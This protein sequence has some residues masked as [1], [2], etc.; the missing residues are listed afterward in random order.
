MT[1]RIAT[2]FLF[3]AAGC[4]PQNASL[5][6]GDYTAYLAELSSGSLITG[7]VDFS[8]GDG[9]EGRLDCPCTVTYVESDDD[10]ILDG[11]V[12][13]NDSVYYTGYCWACAEFLDADGDGEPDGSEDDYS[14]WE[15][16]FSEASLNFDFDRDGNGRLSNAELGQWV[17]NP[18]LSGAD[19][20]AYA[21]P[22]YGFE[23]WPHVDTFQSYN[24]PA[25]ETW[26]GEGI[27]TSEGD[28]QVTFHTYLPGGSDFRFGFTIDPNFQ[29]MD[30]IAD[31]DGIIEEEIDGD[32]LAA[33]SDSANYVDGYGPEGNGP[34]FLLNAGS[35]QFDP[36]EDDAWG[37][38][39]AYWYL[40][41]NWQA[42]FAFG[43][44]ADEDAF[45]RRSQYGKPLYYLLGEE[46]LGAP[47]PLYPTYY[48]GVEEGSSVEDD[49]DW[50][51]MVE[52]VTLIA[53]DMVAEY[54][55]LG[56]DNIRPIIQTNAWRDVDGDDVGLDGWLGMHYNWVQF[57]EGSVI[58]VGET[59]TGSYQL[60]LESSESAS[61]FFLRGT[62]EV[63]NIK[64]D[65]WVTNDVL[66]EKFELS[67]NERCGW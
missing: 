48:T 7:S 51:A 38:G 29:P 13:E 30:C 59:V 25:I 33:W 56:L 46:D 65:F 43:K 21:A 54:E 39:T 14:S 19:A 55:G 12:C 8:Q 23:T 58:E 3:L 20:T 40:P 28:F 16:C 17:H 53:D 15:E 57:D 60:I 1:G 5:T 37:V 22:K 67:G 66:A 31:G 26:R 64:E 61:M 4:T 32:W 35:F 47:S 36:G 50:Q 24:E 11:T 41:E 2:V 49:A 52:R 9:T 10:S 18:W 42:G 27:I 44:F 6:S 34:F 63:K 45:L 62:F